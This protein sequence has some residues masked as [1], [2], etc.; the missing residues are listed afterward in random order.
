MILDRLANHARYV[1]WMPQLAAGFEF[2]T[3]RGRASLEE[4]RHEIDGE[5]VFA[6]VARYETRDYESAEPEAH[7]RYLDIQYVIS[8]RETIYWTPL[9]ETGPESMAYD[10]Q[11][12]LVFFQRNARA[13]PFELAA[14]HFCI[15]FPE[16]AH[17]PNC[18]C[19]PPS[20]VHKAVVKV[21]L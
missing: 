4:G 14:G 19:G 15:F 9:A 3:T 20:P 17:E 12:D 21:A 6:T 8:G 10:A 5:R 18:H 13:R 7:R 2:L 1:S 16:D 11:R